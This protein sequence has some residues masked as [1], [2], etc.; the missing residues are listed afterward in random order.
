MQSARDIQMF[1]SQDPLLD[2]QDPPWASRNPRTAG[3]ACGLHEQRIAVGI[4]AVQINAFFDGGPDFECLTLP[5]A[6]NKY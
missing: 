4:P 1:C 5:Q 2:I 3:V 6:S